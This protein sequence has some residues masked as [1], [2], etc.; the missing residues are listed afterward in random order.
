MQTNLI[1]S[2]VGGSLGGFTLNLITWG[3]KGPGVFFN[4]SHASVGFDDNLLTVIGSKADIFWQFCTPRFHN[5]FYFLFSVE[6]VWLSVFTACI[7]VYKQHLLET[8]FT[9]KLDLNP[10]DIK[11]ITSS[12]TLQILNCKWQ[13]NFPIKEKIPSKI[14]SNPD[15]G[16]IFFL[17][18]LENFSAIGFL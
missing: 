8:N 16:L 5:F 7:I 2:G 18:L 14:A 15:P 12:H 9:L 1:L 17:L 11:A 6:L 4:I 3:C 13:S 10:C